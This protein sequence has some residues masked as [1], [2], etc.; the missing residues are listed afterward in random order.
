MLLRGLNLRVRLVGAF[1]LVCI[2]FITFIVFNYTQI[3]T[4]GSIQNAGFQR[5]KDAVIGNETE[6]DAV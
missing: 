2:F 6:A 3:N 1:M 4:L 5:S